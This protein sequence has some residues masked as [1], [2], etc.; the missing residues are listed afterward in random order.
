M[1]SS[2]LSASSHRRPSKVTPLSF[3]LGHIFAPLKPSH[4]IQVVESRIPYASR[5]H[6]NNPSTN[7]PFLPLSP[8]C[9]PAQRTRK[10]EWSPARGPGVPV[11]LSAW[12]W[13]GLTRRG[14]YISLVEV[15]ARKRKWREE[16]KQ[17]VI[18]RKD[19]NFNDKPDLNS[20]PMRGFILRIQNNLCFVWTLRIRNPFSMKIEFLVL[21]F[22]VVLNHVIDAWILDQDW[23]ATLRLRFS[24]EVEIHRMTEKNVIAS[25]KRVVEVTAESRQ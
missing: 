11:R 21:R 6:Q 5:T 7:H 12:R 1:N 2:Q 18:P 19:E 3:H 4:T 8:Q 15:W 9:S 17:K 13:E 14:A 10:L 25:T 20:L 22:H 16:K 24:L 23:A